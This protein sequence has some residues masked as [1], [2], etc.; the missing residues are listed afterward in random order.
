M[1]NLLVTLFQSQETDL[2]DLNK[3][4]EEGMVANHETKRGQRN[5]RAGLKAQ[6]KTTRT[7]MVLQGSICKKGAL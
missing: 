4:G 7:Y 5:A 2:N 6:G 3:M 1:N